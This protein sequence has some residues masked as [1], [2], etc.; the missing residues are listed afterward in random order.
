[1]LHAEK[2][3]RST[4]KDSLSG[5]RPSEHRTSFALCP[6]S[7]TTKT[8]FPRHL[9]WREKKDSFRA[10]R[11]RRI[12]HRAE[13]SCV[14]IATER[15]RCGKVH[16][17]WS[18]MGRCSRRT[19]PAWPQL[20]IKSAASALTTW[21]LGAFLGEIIAQVPG[22]YYPRFIYDDILHRLSSTRKRAFYAIVEEVFFFVT[23]RLSSHSR[24]KAEETFPTSQL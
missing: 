22:I 17:P 13:N 10:R 19:R 12:T 2:Y 7:K 21:N 18:R 8:F 20:C 9:S 1:M 16:L 15:S 23:S 5:K 6:A 3:S 24:D 4:T 11:A 14:I